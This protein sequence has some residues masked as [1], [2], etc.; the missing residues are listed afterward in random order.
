MAETTAVRTMIQLIGFS[1]EA[2]CLII[3]DQ[4]IDFLD[5]IR[6]LDDAKPANLCK[7][8]RRPG[9]TTG[10]RGFCGNSM[11]APPSD[12]DHEHHRL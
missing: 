11:Q 4:G 3:G 5:E 10:A 1:N 2:A 7:I 9:G 6:T 8:L 12:T